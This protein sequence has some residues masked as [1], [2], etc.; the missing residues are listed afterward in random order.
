MI[1]S[2]SLHLTIKEG[3]YVLLFDNYYLQLKKKKAK[4]SNHFVHPYSYFRIKK[5]SNDNYYI[6]QIIRINYLLS[7]S[8][9]KELIFIEPNSDYKNWT[10][11]EF[12][13]AKNN[14]YAIKNKN[15]CYI[16]VNKFKIT[17][18]NIHIEKASLFHLIKLYEEAKSS[19]NDEKILEKEPIDVL[20]K[21]ID[22]RDS[23]LK[24]NNIHQL[25]K[26]YD[27]EELKYLYFIL[28]INFL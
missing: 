5:K 23:N 10:S 18:Q 4:I 3:I 6:L 9:N 12:I 8:S 20:I 15:N 22:L 27:N 25:E 26:D 7:Y 24:R 21:Y 17:C 14:N 1:I 13:N 28:T 19:E 2:F 11:W 16:K